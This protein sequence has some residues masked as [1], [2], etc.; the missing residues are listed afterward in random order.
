MGIE[1]NTGKFLLAS[2]GSGV[3]F[4]RTLTLGRQVLYI[5]H[6]ALRSLFQQYGS[7]PPN[8]DIVLA[9][10]GN[11][12][13][14]FFSLLGAQEV[15]SLDASD[16][17]GAS[18][19]H[20]LN[21]PLPASHKGQ[22]DL[23]FDGGALEHIF[24]FPVALRNAMEAVKIGGHLLLLTPTNNYCGH[25][26]YQFSPELFYRA[27]SDKNGFK[28]ERMIAFFPFPESQWYEV[29]D[30]A[31]LG[32]RVE[33]AYGSHRVLLLV[34]AKRTHE[35]KLFKTMPQQSDYVI[36]W[37]M[38]RGSENKPSL[39]ASLRDVWRARAGRLPHALVRR[40]NTFM[41]AWANRRLS[42]K[43]QPKL[44]RAIDL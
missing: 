25:G 3:E 2:R 44:F 23:V 21:E 24:N 9:N 11:Y 15:V 18:L 27:L 28:I 36:A 5:H 31:Q 39:M 16:F 26:L 34:L 14:G 30:P 20:D 12:A 10:G 40:C 42:I 1:W 4:K 7:V 32:R 29:V 38:R 41:Y 17:E 43:A 33:I 35:A 13:E 6:E 37:H 8:L 19:M 22:Y